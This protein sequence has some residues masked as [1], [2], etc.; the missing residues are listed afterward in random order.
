MEMLPR[1]TCRRWIRPL[2]A[3]HAVFAFVIPTLGLDSPSLRTRSSSLRRGYVQQRNDDRE[4]RQRNCVGATNRH[5]WTL[6]EFFPSLPA[7]PETGPPH[8][9]NSKPALP[10]RTDS[11]PFGSSATPPTLCPCPSPAWPAHE[12]PIQ[13]V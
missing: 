13:G 2:G 10:F 5:A 9:L 4:Y 6:P 12:F 11:R 3:E 1:R 7:T 8:R